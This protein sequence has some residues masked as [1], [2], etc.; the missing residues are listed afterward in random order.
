MSKKKSKGDVHWFLRQKD[1]RAFAYSTTATSELISALYELHKDMRLVL[2]AINF[3]P[4]AKAI[5]K[6]FVDNGEFFPVIR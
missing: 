6:H 5:V 4:E 1:K 2:D 3:D